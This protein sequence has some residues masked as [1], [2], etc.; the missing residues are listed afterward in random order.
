[1]IP[2]TAALNDYLRMR[3]ALGYKLWRTEKLLAQF[4]TFVEASGSERLTVD[5]ALAWATLPAQGAMDWWSGRLSIVRGFARHLQTLDPTIDVPPAELLPARS[6]RAVPYLYADDDVLALIEAAQ[7]LRCPLRVLTYQ[8]LIGLLAVTGMR[9]GEAIRLDRADLDLEAGVLT[10]RLSKFGKSRELPLHPSTLAALHGYL[11]RRDQLDP[12][13]TDPSLF[14]SMAGKRL[15]YCA[16]HRTFLRLV[17]HAG[18][19]PRSA[20]CRPRPHDLRHSFAVRTVLEAYRSDADVAARLPLLS[21][22]LGH[23]HPA[24][25]YWYLSAAPELLAL[26]GNRLERSLEAPA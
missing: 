9:I 8:T 13:R 15:L 7:I 12:R 5:L 18:L 14:V 23:L 24:N 6:H 2:L 10:I 4:I 26:A 11:E 20:L 17:H 25:T 21:T 19:Q 22:Y 16:V 1:M 3:R